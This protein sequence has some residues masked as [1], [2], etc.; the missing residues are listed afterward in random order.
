MN[1]TLNGRRAK[2][3]TILEDSR[4]SFLYFV[5]SVYSCVLALDQISF[6]EIIGLDGAM[7]YFE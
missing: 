4:R 7:G 5:F 6:L 1:L 2:G 3:G